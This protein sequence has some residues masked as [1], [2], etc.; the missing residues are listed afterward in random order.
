MIFE[1]GAWSNGMSVPARLGKGQGE[2]EI[3]HNLARER[4][5][6]WGQ[7]SVQT[8]KN[9]AQFSERPSRAHLYARTPKI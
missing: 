2:K 1:F 3:G 8:T 5:K 4:P 6:F 9:W 7:F